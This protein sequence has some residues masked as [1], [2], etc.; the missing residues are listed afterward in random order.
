M[1]KPNAL[2]RLIEHYA[3]TRDTGTLLDILKGLLERTESIQVHAAELGVNPNDELLERMN[4]EIRHKDD[5]YG[6][7]TVLITD[8]YDSIT[9]AP[10]PGVEEALA[11]IKKWVISNLIS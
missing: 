6:A 5:V 8:I 10:F 7:I 11:F 3:A 4:A 9:T 2:A 1:I